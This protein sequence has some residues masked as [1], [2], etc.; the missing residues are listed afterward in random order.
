MPPL[1][2]L[3][4]HQLPLT[5]LT[6]VLSHIIKLIIATSIAARY[7]AAKSFDLEDDLEYCPA[8]TMDQV[9]QYYDD[10]T[11]KSMYYPSSTIQQSPPSQ[12]SSPSPPHNYIHP[13]P[14]HINVSRIIANDT[15]GP[16]FRP[17]SRSRGTAAIK[18]IDPNTREERR[19]YY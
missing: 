6:H 18:I 14:P 2:H 12:S 10:I 5:H 3:H 4:P 1:F 15:H 16:V 9:R 7:E 13:S 11:A 19:R 17:P 8:L